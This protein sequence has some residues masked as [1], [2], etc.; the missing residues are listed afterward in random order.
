[1]PW[2]EIDQQAV[3]VTHSTGAPME[4]PVSFLSGRM[5]IFSGVR[6][7]YLVLALALLVATVAWSLRLRKIL[8][9]HHAIQQMTLACDVQFITDTANPFWPLN[10]VNSSG[11]Q[12]AFQMDIYG[13]RNPAWLREYLPDMRSLRLLVLEDE[14]ADEQVISSIALSSVRCMDISLGGDRVTDRSIHMLSQVRGVRQ[15]SLYQCPKITSEAFRSLPLYRK[16]TFLRLNHRFVDDPMAISYLRQCRTLEVIDFVDP[17][18]YFRSESEQLQ[19]L[20][21]AKEHPSAGRLRR[22]FPDCQIRID[23]FPPP[24]AT[25]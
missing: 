18:F 25:E 22:Q 19:I 16:L 14:G 20:R 3:S 5:F 8:R 1:M 15:L 24:S 12:K 2:H 10:G 11:Y 7:R 9:E 21:D 23:Y 6:K 17:S 4:Q 13:D